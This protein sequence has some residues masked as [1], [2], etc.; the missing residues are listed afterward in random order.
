MSDSE[1]LKQI[2]KNQTEGHGERIAVI[3]RDIINYEKRITDLHESKAEKHDLNG[4]KQSLQGIKESVDKIAKN[5]INASVL[6]ANFRNLKEGTEEVKKIVTDFASS[7]NKLQVEV[8]EIKQA[9]ATRFQDL[10]IAGKIL[11]T[12][13]RGGIIGAIVAAAHYLYDFFTGK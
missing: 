6:D 13:S 2:L 9:K 12:I 3:E 1:I 7:V 5:S 10:S 8:A 4:V 11:L